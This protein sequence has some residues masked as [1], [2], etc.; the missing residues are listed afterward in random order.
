MIT[1]KD[2]GDFRSIPKIVSD[3]INGNIA[4]LDK[5]FDE[6]WNIEKKIKIGEY[7]SKSPLDYALIME[8]F[9][10]VKWLIAHGVNLNVKDNPAFLTAVRYCDKE[11]I[12]YLVEHGAKLDGHNNVQSDAFEAAL[13][14]KKYENLS[15][16]HELGHTVQKYGGPAFRGTIGRIGFDRIDDKQ[17]RDEKKYAALD[18]FIKNGVDINYNKPNG[19]YSFKPSPLCVAA[20]YVDLAMCKY[21][22]EHGADITICESGG[23]RPYN[24]AME[25]GDLE[26]AEYFKSL[27]PAQY[28]SLQNKIDELKS[29][30]LSKTLIDFLQNGDLYLDLPDCDFEFIE[31][32]SFVDTVPM[33][34]GRQKLLRISKATGDYNDIIFVWNPKSK[35]IAY[36]DM[37]HE[38]FQDITT[39]EDFISNAAYFMQKVIDG[40]IA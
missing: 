37:E 36:Y 33:K 18:F 14:G 35:C 19:V 3:I 17:A 2:I 20:R 34:I 1:L 27:E 24:I 15:L 29:Y 12:T 16:I 11:I 8:S 38:E 21:L 9:D 10:S 32:F 31:F 5:Y 39:F 6:N 28:H 25:K 4:A 23:M 13:S 7:T 30:K 22:V 26:M 40:D